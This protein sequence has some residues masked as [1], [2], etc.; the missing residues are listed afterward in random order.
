MYAILIG[1]SE[2]CQELN[3]LGA[4]SFQIHA[5]SYISNSFPSTSID[6]PNTMTDTQTQTA[7]TQ[8]RAEIEAANQRLEGLVCDTD[9]EA[10]SPQE[11]MQWVGE[12]FEPSRTVI[13]TSFQHSGMATIHMMHDLRLDLRIATVD[14]LRLHPETYAFIRDVE[15]HYDIEIEVHRPDAAEVESMT[16][17]F[18]EYLFFDSKAKQEYC[19]QVRKT[20]PHDRLLKTADCWISG[21]RRDQ[22]P[23]RAKTPKAMTVSEY[24]SRRLIM[25]LN[26]L[27]DWTEKQLREYTEAHEIPVNGLYA[28]GY[29][30]IG[31]VICSTPT[32]AGEPPRAGR[33]RW[34]NSDG[35]LGQEDL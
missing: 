13:S 22:S 5:L 25:K 14:T 7:T 10:M 23:S 2:Q 17:R 19:C 24:G 20:R 6:G 21:L 28:Q 35:E 1:H 18:G 12:A 8:K 16:Q 4:F 26:P 29:E 34:F 15:Q 27:A 32:T 9:F 11:M 3:G 31:C 33:W 30:S